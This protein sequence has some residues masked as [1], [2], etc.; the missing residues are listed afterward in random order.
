M[1]HKTPANK[2]A[3]TSRND[4][5]PP[6]SQVSLR[7][8]FASK[9]VWEDFQKFYSKMPI[10][11]LLYLTE[12]LL[13]EDKYPVFWRLLDIQGLRPLLFLQECLMAAVATTLRIRDD[14]D[15]NGDGDFQMGGGTPPKSM[16]SFDAK[17]A[18]QRLQVSVI[19]GGKYLVG[20]MS[21]DHRLL[22][23]MLSYI[24]LPRKGN[25]G[26]LIEDDLIILW[27]MVKEVRL[28]WLYLIAWHLMCYT[29]RQDATGLGQ[30]ILWTKIFEHFGIDLSGEDAVPIDEGNAIT[31]RHL[32]KVGIGPKAAVE[33]DV[34]VDEE[35]S[36]PQSVGSVTQFPPELME[37]FTQGMQSFRSSWG[38]NVQRVNRRLDA[39]E[40]RFT[41]H[42][43]EIRDL[44]NDMYSFYG[45]VSPSEDQGFQDSA[46]GHD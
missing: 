21:T 30:G 31:S 40:A 22:Q 43:N 36:H 9:E 41:S 4:P 39:F 14:L 5:P 38:E 2:R 8:W 16:E 25:H 28:N 29:N 6:L 11:K 18:Q 45:R 24:W 26:A 33:E 37:S 17:R 27:A 23:Y 20:R 7:R 42:S 12:G 34:E 32:N 13:P 3:S 1:G 35:G 19:S 46:S 44:G 15:M 10:L